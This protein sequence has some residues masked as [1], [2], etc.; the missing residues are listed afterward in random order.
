MA[1][2]YGQDTWC[3]TRLVTGRYARGV[4]G[5]VLSFFRRLITPRGTLGGISRGTLSEAADA[6]NEDELIFGFD[7][8]AAVGAVGPE[9]AVRTMPAQ[10]RAELMKDDRAVD[11]IVVA[12]GPVYADDGTAEIF[13]DI[14]G[15]LHDPNDNFRFTTQV[16]G[17]SVELLLGGGST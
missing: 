8:G 3:D 13:F 15:Y 1:T 11:V 2:G 17:T 12:R 9:N 7:L 10:I 16:V 4:T 14:E 5:V 6:K